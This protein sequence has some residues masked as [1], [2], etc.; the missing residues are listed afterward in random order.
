MLTVQFFFFFFFSSNS[1]PMQTIKALLPQILNYL[2]LNPSYVPA[3]FKLHFIDGMMNSVTTLISCPEKNV[4]NAIKITIATCVN[5]IQASTGIE[6]QKI[7]PPKP[8]QKLSEH[9][10]L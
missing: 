10:I 4:R 6:Y 5:M 2:F 3:F 9:Q 8:D 1:H 7:D